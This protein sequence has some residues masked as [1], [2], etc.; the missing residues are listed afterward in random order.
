MSI[1][2]INVVLALVWALMLERV[3]ASNLFVGFLL[4]YAALWVT[5]GRGPSAPAYFRKTVRSL[6][7]VIYFLAELV[8]AN[9]KMAIWT[10]TPLRRL[11]PMIIAVP[12]AP[13]LSDTELTILANMI[14]LTP[15]TLSLDVSESRDVL[16]VHFMNVT[17][18]EDE[19]RAIKDGFER[20]LLEVTR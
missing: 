16:F 6:G 1:L 20:R 13:D 14:T 15:G 3:T 9:V 12:L 4:G 10:L 18:P 11:R 7:L 19:I 5:L 2:V 17:S 8:I